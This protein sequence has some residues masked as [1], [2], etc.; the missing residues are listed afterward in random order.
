M[1][2][3]DYFDSPTDSYSMGTKLVMLA[4]ESISGGMPRIWT[5]YDM[6]SNLTSLRDIIPSHSGLIIILAI[7]W[8]WDIE[9]FELNI[10]N[11]ERSSSV[12]S[13][14]FG[15]SC[16]CSDVFESRVKVVTMVKILVDDV[17]L[18]DVPS[19]IGNYHICVVKNK[20]L[21]ADILSRAKQMKLVMQ[22][23][24]GLEGVDIDA[25]TKLGIKVARIPGDVTGNAASCA[26]IAIYLMLG[27]LR[28]QVEF[29]FMD[30]I[31]CTDLAILK[32]R[33]QSP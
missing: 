1:E 9:I 8:L 6:E 13:I 27:L 30:D 22:F 25:A 21:A 10:S 14:G 15:I 31:M 18:D 24:V 7:S 28:K 29:F 17:P 16:G 5:Q 20:R 3:T 19:V 4:L 12:G 26:E 23:G 11:R 33:S 32:G 2:R